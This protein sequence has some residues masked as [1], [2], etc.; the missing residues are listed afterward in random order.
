M[1]VV[2]QFSLCPWARSAREAGE[3][4]VRVVS[5]NP[6]R[7]ARHGRFSDEGLQVGVQAAALAAARELLASPANVICLVVVLDPGCDRLTLR[8]VRTAATQA[9]PSAG[10][11]DFHPDGPLDTTTPARLVSFLR[12]APDP[13]IQLVPF[14]ILDGVRSQPPTMQLAQQVQQLWQQAHGSGV[15]P[16]FPKELMHRD[17]A[18]TIAERNHARIAPDGGSRMAAVLADIAADREVAYTRVGLLAPRD[19]RDGSADAAPSLR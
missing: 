10:V 17:I 4:A 13:L 9:L 11:A 1:E 5:G 18:D 14:R 12:R 7:T 15:A 16:V 3:V 8:D 6:A 2:E 19:M